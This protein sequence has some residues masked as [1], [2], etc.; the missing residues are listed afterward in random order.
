MAHRIC[1]WWLGYALVNPIRRL[2]ENPRRIF[3]GFVADGMTVLE[4]G[5]GMGFFTLELARLVGPSGRVVA[6]DVQP[7]MLAGLKRRAARAGLAGRID[8]RLATDG[9]LGI[10]D[11]AGAADAAV[12][13][14]VVHEVPDQRAFLAELFA[15]LRPGGRLLVVEPG[16]HVTPADFDATMAEA[17]AVG[18]GRESAAPETRGLVAMLARPAGPA[19]AGG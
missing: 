12:V 3:Q 16:G 5:C 4:P 19:G 13:L 18:F 2:L 9:T 15:A 14:H 7:R 6:V 8:A 17:A 10:G 1:P 11:L